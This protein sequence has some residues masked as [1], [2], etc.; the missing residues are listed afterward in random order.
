M[1]S[2]QLESRDGL[3]LPLPQDSDLRLVVGD[4]LKAEKELTPSVSEVSRRIW[5]KDLQ[6]LEKIAGYDLDVWEADPAPNQVSLQAIPISRDWELL[7]SS[8]AS[9]EPQSKNVSSGH[10]GPEPSSSG[11]R[12]YPEVFYGSPGPPSSQVGPVSCPMTPFCLLS[13]TAQPFQFV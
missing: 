1:D 5:W 9:A 2:T 4:S 3:P 11:Q 7:P 12:L 8:S 13:L 6:F 10:C